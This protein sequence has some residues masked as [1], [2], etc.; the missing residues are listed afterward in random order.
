MKAAIVGAGEIGK[1]IDHVLEGA[2]VVVAL[3]DKDAE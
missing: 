2:G 1:A 3:W